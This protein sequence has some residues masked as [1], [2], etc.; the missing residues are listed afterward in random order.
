MRRTAARLSFA[1]LVAAGAVPQAQQPTFRL[2]TELVTMGVTVADRR[3][4][5]LTDLGRNDFDV[6]EDGVVQTIR[7][8]TRGDEVDAGPELH[9]GL[10]FDTSGSMEA[11]ISLSRSAAIRFLNTLDWAEDMTLVDFDTEV[12]VT[13]FSQLEFPRLVER[14]RS[15]TPAGYTAMYDALGVYLSGATYGPGRKIL[16]IFTDGGDTHSALRYDEALTLV[17]ASDVTVYAIGFLANQ[18][19][20]RRPEQRLRLQQIAG[21][22]GGE[23]FFPLSMKQI[24]EA[25]DRILSGIRGQYSL[26]YVSTNTAADGTWRTV[27]V[28]V[29]R[30]NA[31][32]LRVQTRKGYFAPFREPL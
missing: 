20:R 32:N 26:G 25:Y 23:A 2:E 22:S 27:E 15:R 29:R 24:E 21:E 5:V 7:Y 31:R 18:S 28:R 17:R 10:L 9:V 3:G 19:T 11:D 6:L 8:F 13:R 16:V 30:P 14:I 1:V 4:T 12:R